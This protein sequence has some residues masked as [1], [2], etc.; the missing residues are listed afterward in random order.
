LSG[1]LETSKDRLLGTLVCLDFL[2][3]YVCFKGLSVSPCCDKQVYTFPFSNTLVE[4]SPTILVPGNAEDNSN[5]Y[6]QDRLQKIDAS[7]DSKGK[8]GREKLNAHS[9]NVAHKAES[10]KT[11]GNEELEI[12]SFKRIME[13]AEIDDYLRAS[14]EYYFKPTYDINYVRKRHGSGDKKFPWLMGRLATAITMRRKYLKYRQDHPDSISVL[15]SNETNGKGG[16]NNLHP[17][18]SYEP[19]ASAQT[20]EPTRREIKVPSPPELAFENVP[21][22]FGKTFQCPYC[23]TITTVQNRAAWKYEPFYSSVSLIE[24]SVYI[25]TQIENTFFTT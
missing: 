8:T 21:F 10:R 1:K 9:S 11:I 16:T 14:M 23:Y 7:K 3:K 20:S 4:P 2:E 15:E 25:L 19:Q 22:E 17:R 6:D 24:S 18:V 5:T 12:E 13:V